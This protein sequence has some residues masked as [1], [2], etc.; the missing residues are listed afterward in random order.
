MSI[1]PQ[2]LHLL[3]TRESSELVYDG[4]FLKVRRDM[5]RLP[6]EHVVS[7]EYVVHPGAVV[8]IPLLDDGRVLLERQ[9]RYPIERVMTEFPAGKL[10]PGEDP[11]ACAK[12]ELLEETGY[13]AA[14]WARAGALH[15]AIA[16]STEIIHIYFARGLSA[17]ER[18]LDADEFLDVHGATLP[19]LLQAC[20]RGEVTDAK[21]LT[22]ML[23]LQNAM[24]GAWELDW[25]AA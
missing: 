22:C 20:Q 14:Q 18:R 12:R 1:D 6:N 11:L 17:G 2:E 5:V 8:V 4:R 23:W 3:E 24:S 10:D 19:A 21:T 7:R 25:Q 13:T 9:Y 15:L 16:Y